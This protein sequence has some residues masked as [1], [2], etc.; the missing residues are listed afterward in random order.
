MKASGIFEGLTVEEIM[1]LAKYCRLSSY[2]SGDVVLQEKSRNSQIYIVGEGNL[3]ESRTTGDGMVKSLRII[4][5][6]SVFGI[7]SLFPEGKAPT[8]YTAVSSQVKIVEIN[9]DVL[10]EVFRRKPEGWLALLQKEN[11]QKC[12]LQR[13]WTME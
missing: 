7:E 6:G 8:S 11:D 10:S 4:K 3:E 1:I 12:K 5:E 13:L 9:K 2:L